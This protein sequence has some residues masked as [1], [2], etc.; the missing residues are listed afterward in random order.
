MD[1]SIRCFCGVL[2]E[3]K[4]AMLT[5]AAVFVLRA[6]FG[7]TL[8]SHGLTKLLSYG[9]MSA[10]FPDPLGVGNAVSLAMVIFAEFFCS[11]AV[12]LG[13]MTRLALLP[14]IFNMCVILG[15]VLAHAEF[16]VKELALLYLI[17]FVALFLHGPGRFSLDHLIFGPLRARCALPSRK[18]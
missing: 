11:L 9:E 2:D 10:S 5:D 17:A 15:V 6:G 1:K 14:L 4:R 3:G 13:L 12:V 18:T 16:K 7:L 8:M